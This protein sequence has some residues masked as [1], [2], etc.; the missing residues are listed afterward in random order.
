[1]PMELMVCSLPRPSKLMFPLP[2]RS[3]QALQPRLKPKFPFPLPSVDAIHI[4]NGT[5]RFIAYK[6]CRSRFDILGC[7]CFLETD[8]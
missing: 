6:P 1:L 4:S 7:V 5:P 3:R 2:I 8:F